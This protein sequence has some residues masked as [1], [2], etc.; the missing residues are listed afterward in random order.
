MNKY[1]LDTLSKEMKAKLLTGSVIPR[2]I[3]WVTSQGSNGVLNMAPFS[4]FN[5]VSTDPPYVS[6]SIRWDDGIQKDTSKNIL[7]TKEFV[8]HIVDSDNLIQANETSYRYPSHIS[9]VERCGLQKVPSSMVKVDGIK[10]AKIR[11]EVEYVTHLHLETTDLFIGKVLCIHIDE[12]IMMSDKV[13]PI[14]L[15]VMSRIGGP[16]YAAIGDIVQLNKPTISE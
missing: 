10:E 9:E 16:N 11:M 1:I 6:V 14:K 8:I 5:L 13:D 4:Y 2:P 3:A 7:E 12:D 15:K